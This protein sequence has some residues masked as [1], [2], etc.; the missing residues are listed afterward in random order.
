[1]KQYDTDYEYVRLEHTIKAIEGQL[2][3]EINLLAQSTE[4][5]RQLQEELTEHVRAVPNDLGSL[6]ELWQ[7]Q[8]FMDAMEREYKVVKERVERLN[9]L[10]NSPYFARIDFRE[11]SMQEPEQIYI[12]L[13]NLT[14][15]EQQDFLVYDWRAPI[16]SLFY[17]YEVGN[18]Q[19]ESPAGVVKG[20][21]SLKRQFKII[22]QKI[23]YM[24]DSSIKIDDEILQEILSSNADEKMKT[25]VASIQREQNT[26]IRNDTNKVLIV[27]GP[28]GSGKTSIALH[29]A[30]YL[31]YKHRD[32]IKSDNI[33]ILSP[34]KIFSSYIS[35]VLPELGEDNIKEETFYGYFSRYDKNIKVE[36]IYDQMDYILKN[37]SDQKRL[38]NIKYKT[39][40]GFLEILDS[41]IEE[42]QSGES[43][44][45]QD[46][47]FNGN[48]VM[49]KSE[50]KKLF[51]EDRI[52]PFN[53]R[54]EILR[55]RILRYLNIF[56]KQRF[57]EI[58][59]ELAQQDEYLNSHEI[60]RKARAILAV[61]FEDVKKQI[62]SICSV[63]CQELYE[64]IAEPL[65]KEGGYYLYEDW[66]ALVYMKVMLGYISKDG[67]IKH[68][69]IDEAQDYTMM[70]YKI[71]RKVF[72]NARV[73]ILGDINQ[74][75]NHYMNIKDYDYIVR[76]YTGLNTVKVLLKKS[77]RST[78]QIIDF[79]KNIIE[80]PYEAE[81]FNRNGMPPQLSEFDNLNDLQHAITRDIEILKSE[82]F[83]SFAIICRT[84]A[85]G[86]RL[87]NYLKNKLNLRL[88][89]KDDDDFKKGI[90]IIP[91]YLSKGLEFDAV[92]VFAEDDDYYPADERNLLYTVC[93]RAMHRLN[94]YML[95][96]RIARECK[97]W[98]Q[99]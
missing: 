27:H 28:A 49:S 29:K 32:Y 72:H 9:K 97:T 46:I 21:L 71:L 51:K 74:L 42:L 38:E 53:N 99:E 66:V 31:L 58:K 19:Y 7:Y 96:A 24:F 64:R 81:Y 45:F 37:K 88:I 5:A 41:Y 25:I 13:S 95:N 91:S 83:E 90:L 50:M 8:T 36:S 82:G 73:T 39:S 40:Q 86:R 4:Y 62:D 11:T 87:Y 2:Q 54:L 23:V 75:V 65:Y 15:E 26:V 77:Y 14:D 34:N 69:I 84:A 18:A 94:L 6:T 52:L 55:Q 35:N 47:F 89:T 85:Q 98:L 92:F 63:D 17:D 93:T 43:N 61:E 10:K 68:L 20:N 1:M 67:S 60:N 78:R 80:D 57:N 22:N 33:L 16:S 12:G 79:C 56:E 3:R 48:L 59:Q 70:Q 30:A 44:L 76:A